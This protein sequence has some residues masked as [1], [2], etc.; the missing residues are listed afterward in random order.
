MQGG[1]SVSNIN[2][3]IRIAPGKCE[4]YRQERGN[5]SAFQGK[6]GGDQLDGW[7]SVGMNCF[8]TVALRRGLNVF[9][10]KGRN[11][12]ICISEDSSNGDCS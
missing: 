6:A 4:S 9:Q 1:L 2:A 12:A 8:N 10:R 11:K 3:G 7:R 5:A